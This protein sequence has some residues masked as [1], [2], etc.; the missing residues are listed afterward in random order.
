MG[1]GGDENFTFEG[2]HDVFL[3]LIL[4]ADTGC[5]LYPNVAIA[6]PRSPMHLTVVGLAIVAC[7]TGPAS[8]ADVDTAARWMIAFY[9]STSAYLPVLETEGPAHPHPELRAKSREGRWDEMAAL[10]DAGLR[11]S[12]G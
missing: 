8:Q 12:N 3:P 6:F 11:P 1:A 5:H 4:A 2:P 10:L 9:V 7:A